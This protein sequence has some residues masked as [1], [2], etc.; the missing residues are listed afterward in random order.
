M[1]R[2]RVRVDALAEGE[3]RLQG[4][5]AHHL[6]RV[7]RARPGQPIA[8]FDGAGSEA[9]G[10]ITAV[11][12]DGVLVRLEAPRA[13]ATEPDRMVTLAPALLKGDKLA[14]VVRMATE[15][16]VVSVRPVLGRRCDATELS[17]TRLARWR[18]VAQ[19]A[20][21][22]C[23]RARVPEVAEAVRLDDLAWTGALLVADPFAEATLGDVVTEMDAAHDAPPSSVTIVTGPE[24]GL[25]PDEVAALIARGGRVVALGRRVLRAETAP[26]AV[27]AALLTWDGT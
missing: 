17:P 10:T 3:R 13:A 20:A 8:A 26:V 4:P 2:H 14:D 22:Q 15:L 24:G 12:A 7:L 19:E 27:A 25:T 1:R 23:G 16:G 11:D 6:A 9:F 21:R 5:A 18:R